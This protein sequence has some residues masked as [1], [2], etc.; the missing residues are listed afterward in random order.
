MTI[1]SDAVTSI[2]SISRSLES[3]RKTLSETLA[4]PFFSGGVADIERARVEDLHRRVTTALS[5]LIG[6]A[7]DY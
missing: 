3:T 7:R 1:S 6:A 5:A 2:A 4:Q